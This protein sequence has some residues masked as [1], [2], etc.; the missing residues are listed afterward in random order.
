MTDFST[1]TRLSCR[2]EVPGKVKVC[3]NCGGRMQTS[4][5]VRGLGI[6]SVVAGLVIVVLIGAISLFMVPTM[7][8]P[9]ET[10][11]GS[12]FN[13][14]TQQATMILGLFAV[15]IVFGL[16]AIANGTAMAITGRR[17]IVLV[18]VTFVL[19]VVLVG[20]GWATTRALSHP[21]APPPVDTPAFGKPDQTAS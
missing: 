19:A 18:V 7:M 17:N 21:D 6:V 3:P 1:C 10:V 13:G 15:L 9:G 20:A 16:T 5:L 4:G 12:S 8:H 14:T 2:S 11:G